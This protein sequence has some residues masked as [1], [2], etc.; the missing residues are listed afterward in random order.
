MV[1]LSILGIYEMGG[2]LLGK[3]KENTCLRAIIMM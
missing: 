3:R 2:H 1:I